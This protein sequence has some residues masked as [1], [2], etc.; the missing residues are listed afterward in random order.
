MRSHFILTILLATVILS[1]CWGFAEEI[2]IIDRYHLLAVDIDTDMSLSYKLKDGNYVG[3][4]DQTV[5]SV[6]FNDD[7]IIAKQHPDNDHNTINYFIL[8]IIKNYTYSPDDGLIGPLTMK[9]FE[10]KTKEL[11]IAQLT[12]TKTIEKLK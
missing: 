4:V 12:F 3:I 7:Y 8:P 2:Q 11:G 5:F 6:G 9:Q 1:S 10:T